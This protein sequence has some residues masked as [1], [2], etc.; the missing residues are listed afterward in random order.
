VT[1]TA[2][3][4]TRDGWQ[5][6][7]TQPKR[8]PRWWIP[9]D[10]ERVRAAAEQER[11][12]ALVATPFSTPKTVV[13]ANTKGGASKTTVSVLLASALGEWSGR[14]V[15][16]IDNNPTGT[17]RS[18]LP[19]VPESPPS[20]ADL[21][22]AMD[23]IMS[24]G[25]DPVSLQRYMLY[26]SSNKFSALVARIEATHM[27]NGMRVLNEPTLSLQQ[28]VDAARLIAR[29]YPF[30]VVDSGNNNRDSQWLGS[31]SLADALVIAT[32]WD[33]DGLQGVSDMLRTEFELGEQGGVDHQQ[34]A[35]RAIIVTSQGPGEIV[36]YNKLMAE[37]WWD[38]WGFTHLIIPTDPAIK[39]GEP[40]IWSQLSQATRD[41]ALSICAELATRFID[42]DHASAP[43]LHAV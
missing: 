23:A 29:Q 34:L 8:K 32:S 12:A 27:E 40:I 30:T 26:Q 5:K 37:A 9:G 17:L 33:K 31:I 21:A 28:Y 2:D 35:Q 43:R 18:R 41:V 1:P 3:T 24:A 4:F 15:A 13:V 10:A 39:N 38:K 11:K 42:R 19:Y 36:E 22:E 6:Q 20:L 25:G 14:Q 16:L 7:A